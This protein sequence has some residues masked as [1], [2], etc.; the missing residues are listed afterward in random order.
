MLQP[1]RGYRF[2]IQG[3]VATGGDGEIMVLAEG[4]RGPLY[5]RGRPAL[6]SCNGC[7]HLGHVVRG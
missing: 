4:D 1:T 2:I 6:T 7:H 5:D 3:Q